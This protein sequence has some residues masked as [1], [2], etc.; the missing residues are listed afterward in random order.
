MS[1]VIIPASTEEVILNSTF[2]FAGTFHWLRAREVRNPEKHFMVTRDELET[3]VVTSAENL[4]D[5]DAVAINPDRWILIAI[6]CA[7]PFYCVGFLAR[8][9]AALSAAGLDILVISTF[10]RDC[11]MVKESEGEMAADVLAAT[12][13]RRG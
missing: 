12:G 9:S 5:V 8:I 1:E 3:T 2:R 10:S 11:I 6:D 13:L 4:G 7:S